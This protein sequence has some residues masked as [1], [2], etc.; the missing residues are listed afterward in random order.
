MHWIFHEKI[1]PRAV[2]GTLVALTGAA[3]LFLK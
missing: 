3:L 2:I 1:T